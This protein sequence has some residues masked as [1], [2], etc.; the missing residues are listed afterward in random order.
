V[1][2]DKAPVIFSRFCLLRVRT[3]FRGGRQLCR[4]S[5]A[6]CEWFGPE[7]MEVVRSHSQRCYLPASSFRYDALNVFFFFAI[8]SSVG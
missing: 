4:N 3:D 2:P 1:A 7:E 5:V 8:S 6:A